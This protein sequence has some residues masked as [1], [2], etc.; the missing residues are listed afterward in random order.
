[1]ARVEEALRPVVAEAELEE[2]PAVDSAVGGLAAA[3]VAA[4]VVASVAVASVA[5][6]AAVAAVGSTVEVLAEE[7]KRVGLARGV[8]VVGS[9]R[10]AVVQVASGR[11]VSV[12]EIVVR[13]ARADSVARQTVARK[14][15]SVRLQAL[16]S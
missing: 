14:A 2:G 6:V 3:L 10:A 11:V 5:A 15:D 8:P 1:M 9:I 7:C 4:K 16:A 13:R 12:E